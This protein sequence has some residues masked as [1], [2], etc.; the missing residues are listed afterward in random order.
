MR[1]AASEWRG[2]G[3]TSFSFICL[4]SASI[5][6]RVS[7]TRI[8]PAGRGVTGSPWRFLRHAFFATKIDTFSDDILRLDAAA[9]CAGA[10]LSCR[11]AGPLLPVPV[12]HRVG[13]LWVGIP[14]R[15]WRSHNARPRFL[16]ASDPRIATLCIT[17]VVASRQYFGK[18]SQSV[19]LIWIEA[20]ASTTETWKP[21][22]PCCNRTIRRLARS[23]RPLQ[24]GGRRPSPLNSQSGRKSCSSYQSLISIALSFSSATR[25]ELALGDLF[26]EPLEEHTDTGHVAFDN[27]CEVEAF[28]VSTQI[29]RSCGR[30]LV[31]AE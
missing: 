23:R 12:A 17:R 29:R 15:S 21:C 10:S 2:V 3:Q 14:S 4:N 25:S 20:L 18:G 28:W 5:L 27:R 24:S 9:D 26:P 31:P 8:G 30:R 19:G 13:C 7:G 6:N 1:T 11:V 16:V 22:V